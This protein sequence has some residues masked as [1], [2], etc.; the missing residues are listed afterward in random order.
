MITIEMSAKLGN[1]KLLLKRIY[2]NRVRKF[3]GE[4]LNKIILSGAHRVR[5]N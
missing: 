3:E 1:E 4:T 5:R 2:P